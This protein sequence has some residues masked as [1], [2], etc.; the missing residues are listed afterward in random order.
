VKPK[1]LAATAGIGS[2]LVFAGCSTN[3]KAEFGDVQRTIKERSGHT[4]MWT[5]DE[6]GVADVQNQI[7]ALLQTN[8]TVEAAV[9]IALVNNPRLQAT[10]EEIGIA[11]ADLVQA[12]LLRNPR[13]AGSWR[14][15]DSPPSAANT[16]YSVTGDILNAILL[17]LRKKIAARNLG[18]V[19]LRVADEVL[20]LIAEVKGAF[21]TAQAREQLVTRIRI[22]VDVNEAS[23]EIA[24]RRHDAGN[25]SDLEYADEKAIYAQSR[26]NLAEA[27]KELRVD[28]E[29]LNRLLGLWGHYTA[30]HLAD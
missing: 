20:R 30:W 13:F 24:K 8:L 17:P 7:D 3:P 27:Q 11:K 9:Q 16:E 26:V 6:S 12:G 5:R 19:K 15:P 21:Y 29:R 4:V 2:I 10:F 1:T 22:I 18:A 14:F 25:I 28:R 23:A